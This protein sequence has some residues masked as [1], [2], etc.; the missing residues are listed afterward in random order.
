MIKRECK[1]FQKWRRALVY[2]ST[3]KYKSP[4]LKIGDTGYMC[5][6]GRY[7]WVHG[8]YLPYNFFLT[9]EI[10]YS[11][12]K[13]FLYFSFCKCFLLVP[14]WLKI[15]QGRTWLPGSVL[16]D[17]ES[18]MLLLFESCPQSVSYHWV[19]VSRQFLLNLQKAKLMQTE[20]RIMRLTFQH[21][22]SAASYF[23]PLK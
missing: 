23:K 13:F 21:H 17:N 12:F 15:V 19:S 5:M 20:C 11:P 4:L 7:E 2:N 6:W 10:I 1:F 14:P 8:T 9:S 18:D 3:W 16:K 22:L